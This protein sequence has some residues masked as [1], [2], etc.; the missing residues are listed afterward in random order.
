VEFLVVN[1]DDDGR[2]VIVNSAPGAWTT[3]QILMLEAG[4]YYIE[5]APPAD[6]TPPQIPIQLV[7]TT[8]DNPYQ[9]YFTKNSS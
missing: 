6:F 5:L 9:L 8:V 2:G 3:N 7:G 1:F 4:T